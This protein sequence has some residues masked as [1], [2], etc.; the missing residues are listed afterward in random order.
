MMNASVARA[1]SDQA[2]MLKIGSKR[3]KSGQ[4]KKVARLCVRPYLF[5]GQNFIGD[6]VRHAFPQFLCEL[7][8]E[9]NRREMRANEMR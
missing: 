4:N 6:M 7:V 8:D 2:I 3:W 9:L 5:Q 1:A